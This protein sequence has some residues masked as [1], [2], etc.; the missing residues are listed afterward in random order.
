[1]T[2]T[3]LGLTFGGKIHF[4]NPFLNTGLSRLSKSYLENI[5]KRETEKYKSIY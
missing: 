4:S 5:S 1:M 3:F 2:D